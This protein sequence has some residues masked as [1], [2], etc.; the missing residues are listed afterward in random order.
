MHW[1][2]RLDWRP[3]D[4]G[5]RIAVLFMIGASCFALGS[6]PLYFRNIDPAIVGATFFVGSVFF[7]SASYSQYYQ[8]INDPANGSRG[9]RF[10]TW[11][12]F[13]KLWWATAVQFLGT[14]FFNVT[15]F[16]AM[17]VTNPAD[18]NQL[19]WAPDFFGSIA[20]LVASH[21]AWLA[22]CGRVWCVDR[23][24]RDWWVAALNYVGSI[25]FMLA[26]IASFTLPTTEEMVNVAIVN[27]GTFLGA[28]CFFLGAYLLLDPVGSGD[29]RIGHP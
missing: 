12:P 22:V 29:A 28:V 9:R 25:F 6:V 21:F 19:V 27:A 24:D 3:R 20:F 4:L 23:T 11:Q 26:A 2:R 5:W 13:E 7:T 15:T 1:R 18:V 10:F 16:R 17:W 14:L 8:V